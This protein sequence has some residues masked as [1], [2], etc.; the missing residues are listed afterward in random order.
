MAEDE[1]K[2]SKTE[3]PT[4]R[5]LT[6]AREKGQV[7]KSK[8]VNNLFT[9]LAIFLVLILSM[10]AHMQDLLDIYGGVLSDAGTIRVSTPASMGEYTRIVLEKSLW[11]II[12]TLLLLMIFA[13]FGGFI[14]TG[15]LASTEP[16]IPKLSKISIIKGFERMFS[17]KSIMEFIKSIIKLGILGA[18]LYF[19]LYIHRD[20]FLLATDKSVGDVVNTTHIIA[21][22][23]V[24]A[25]IAIMIIL[26]VID[27]L[28]QQSEFTKEQRMSRR[29][30]KDEMKESEGDPYVKNRQRQLRQEK[31]KQ[32]MM[33]ELPSADVVVTN[34][35]HFSVALKYDPESGQAAPKVIAKGTDHIAMKIREVAKEN[36]IPLYEDPPLARQLYADVDLDEEVPVELFEATAK[37]IAYVMNLKRKKRAA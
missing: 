5:K 22:R 17:L 16:I 13:Y 35:T 31:A 20:Y 26:A 14:Q 25:A 36:D 27:F 33:Q 9:L 3:E 4:Q 37:V 6:K 2:S 21:I 28:F 15:P 7:P 19:V 32:R 30:I 10:P 8:E 1:D 24:L 34:P 23:M 11:A 18:A 12:P 29:E